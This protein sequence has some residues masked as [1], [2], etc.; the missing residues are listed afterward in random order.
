MASFGLYLPNVGFE[1]LLSPAELI[2]YTRRAED[3][4]FDSVWVEDRL[5]HRLPIL[6]ALTTLTFLASHTTRLKLGT[7][8]LLVNLRTALSLAKSLSSLDY[9]TGGRLILG[10]SLGGREDEYLASGASLKRR[11]RRFRET[12][13][14]MRAFWG[15]ERSGYAADPLVV[16]EPAMFPSPAAP[17]PVWIGGRAEPVLRR[18]AEIG[19][20]WLASGTL[21]PDEFRSLWARIVEHC[22]TIGR[23]PATIEP[24]KFSYIHIDNNRQQAL[25]LLRAAV[26][27]YYEFKYDVERNSMYGSVDDCVSVAQHILQAGARTLIF[28]PVTASLDQIEGI[29]DDILPALR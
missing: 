16:K 2:D 17:I 19:D 21:R 29:A 18:V 22:G 8:V 27:T 14:A 24:A 9:L 26:S 5:L 28:Y 12:I 11:V 13:A 15:Q 3:L 23:D 25:E 6:E 20:G 10:A 1:G 4:G 7:S